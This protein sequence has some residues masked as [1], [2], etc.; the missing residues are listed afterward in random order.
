MI[1]W[2][3]WNHLEQIANLKNR[4][5]ALEK[6][7]EGCE[8]EV[9]KLKLDLEALRLRLAGPAKEPETIHRKDWRTERAEREA[10]HAIP[11]EKRG[12]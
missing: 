11:K 9:Q 10:K 6:R 5:E 2:E 8:A 4:N 1:H 12:E 3:N 7:I